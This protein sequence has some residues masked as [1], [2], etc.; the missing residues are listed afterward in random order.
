MKDLPGP[1]AQS[2]GM[3]SG[4]PCAD[5]EPA[6]QQVHPVAAKRGHFASAHENQA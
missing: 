4:D 2:F 3:G 5:D 6:L 1:P